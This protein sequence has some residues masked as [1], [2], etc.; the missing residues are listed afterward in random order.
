MSSGWR[1]VQSS[2]DDGFADV[3]T[4]IADYINTKIG[5]SKYVPTEFRLTARRGN[6]SAGPG[7]GDVIRIGFN[8]RFELELRSRAGEYICGPRASRAASAAARV[9]AIAAPDGTLS[10]NISDVSSRIVAYCNIANTV[11]ENGGIDLTP[12]LREPYLRALKTVSETLADVLRR[13]VDTVIRVKFASVATA[14]AQPI[15]VSSN[16]WLTPNL[17]NATVRKLEFAASG[18]D[19]LANFDLAL[20]VRPQ[21]SIGVQ[22]SP[23]PVSVPSF[24]N[25]PVPD[26]FHLAVDI[27]VPFDLLV[28]RARSSLVGN[29]IPVKFIGTIRID[30]VDIYATD[31]GTPDAPKPKVVVQIG[32]SGGASGK[33][34]VWG[35]PTVD[36]AT[37]VISLPDL[38]FTTDTRHTLVRLLAP[39]L[40]SNLVMNRVRSAATFDASNLIDQQTAQFMK[41]YDYTFTTKDGTQVALHG[42]PAPIGLNGVSVDATSLIVHAVVNGTLTASVEAQADALNLR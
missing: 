35:T 41:P 7:Q 8:E 10:T 42:V 24:S 23:M 18:N 14:L 1:A 40:Q 4:I 27:H 29:E 3:R 2:S 38:D 6:V 28:Q 20:A 31:G 25:L 19:L 32:F 12:V 21:V 33:L 37:R 26:G 17:Q 36:P 30:D 22:P 34:Y 39:L 15:Q 9:A 16:A 5:G 13:V 11:L